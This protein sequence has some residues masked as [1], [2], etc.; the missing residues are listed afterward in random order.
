MLS[1]KSLGTADSGIASYYESLSA[2]DY[3]QAGAEPPGL[4]HGQLCGALG[5]EGNVRAGQLRQLFEGFDPA[6]GKAL[7]SN[8]GEKHKA[9]WDFTF[10]A[11]KSVSVAWALGHA[12]LQQQI[13]D[14]HDA[15]VRAGLDYLE[16]NAFASRDRGGSEPLKG[17]IAATYQ[18]STSREL[19]PQL[20]SHC[21]VA[22]IGLRENGTVCAVD[23]DSRWKMAA[24]AVYRAELAHQLQ[25]LG[26]DIE[27]DAKSFKLAAIPEDLCSTFSKRRRQ[28]VEY[29]QQTGFTSAKSHDIAALA[30]RKAK[31]LSDR[32]ILRQ[33]WQREA[34]TAGYS[35][36]ELQI[37]LTPGAVLTA[38]KQTTLNV[39]DIVAGLT[40]NEAIFTRQ[41]LEAAIATAAQGVAGADEI[42]L[43]VARA[44]ESGIASTE[45][46]GLVRL[47]EAG[48]LHDSRRQTVLYTTREM[49]AMETEAIVGA[50]NRRDERQHAVVVADELLNGLSAEQ[51]DAVRHITQ[52]SG[53]VAC[54]RGLAGTGKSHMLGRARA[55]W[56]ASGYTVIGAALAGKA[57]DG[58]QA[59]SGIASQTLHSLLTDIEQGRMILSSKHV[60][61]VD[62][63]GMVGT[64]QLHA[65]LEHIH[66]AGGAKTV[67]V[68]D[69]QQLQPISAGGVFRSI[70][71]AVGYAGLTEIRRQTSEQDRAMIKQLIGG[72]AAEV[73][74]QLSAAGQLLV[75]RDDIVVSAMVDDWLANRDPLQPGETLML[76]GTRADVCKLNRTAREALKAAHRLHSE[77]SVATEH[78]EQEFAV[79]ERVLFTRNSRLLGV[80]NGQ[81]GTLEGWRL[82]VHTGNIELTVRQDSGEIAIFDPTQYGHFSHGYAVSVHKAQ[83]VTADSVSV[84][85]SDSM[86]D[87]EWSYVAVSRHRQRLRVFVPEG[88]GGDLEGALSRSRQKTLASD[89]QILPKQSCEQEC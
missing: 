28:I 45:P 75:E 40:Q 38:T 35:Q 20:H 18:H 43:I 56:E 19:D 50:V 62:E 79:G 34:E 65:L 84:L 54:V 68:G 13:A 51:A 46:L 31:E 86:T 89:Y 44:I 30:T 88:I 12:E 74:E 59:G 39:E 70:S 71:E 61:V 55:A 6:T 26:L 22:N 83:G 24:G 48:H 77:I 85:L 15:A 69:A 7:A 29:I 49:L 27:R 33:Q 53:G 36:A 57:A 81:L 76:A 10:S 52:N 87:R 58:L 23:F 5:L 2:D 16:R 37:M 11:P 4:W 64:R 73:I 72:Q 41:Q 47:A 32:E 42:P 60:V 82:N 63:C 8:A 80:K 66:A 1:T 25:Q 14:A 21:A 9:G 3:Y 17:I 67:W 78:G